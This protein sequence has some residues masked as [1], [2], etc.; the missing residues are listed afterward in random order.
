[1]RSSYWLALGVLTAAVAW[2]ATG[3]IGTDRPKPAEPGASR[4]AAPAL[5]S[6]RVRRLVAEPYESQVTLR[7]RSETNRAVQLRGETIGQVVGVP[8]ARGAAVAEGD[9]LV[10]LSEDDRAAR[11]ADAKALL[12]QRE[13]EYRASRTLSQRGYRADNAHA[14]S[15]AQLAA[16]RAVVARIELDIARRT[17]RAPFAGVLES[18]KVEIGDYVKEGDPVATVVD[19][20]PLLLVGN[21]TER[22]RGRVALGD[23]GTARLVTGQT[24]T[25]RVRYLAATADPATRTFRVEVE[26]SNPDR[27]LPAGVTAEI[28]LGSE[29]LIAHR[30]TP[31]ILTLDEAGVVGV[32]TVDGAGKVVFNPVRIVA[33]GPE[34]MW[35]T[36]LPD[37]ATVITVGQE[38]VRAGQPVRPVPDDA[39]RT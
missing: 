38:Y 28:R 29:R 35:I 12:A 23:A 19:L 21:L 24:V 9:A 36:G 31:A 14:E 25:G 39:A 33:D 15:E 7:G 2:V 11:L 17:I 5:P 34:G 3:Q 6:V 16:A 13:V 10:V 37:E 8:V 26:V 32:K 22:D 27:A 20:D 1:M 4:D 18:R 30:I